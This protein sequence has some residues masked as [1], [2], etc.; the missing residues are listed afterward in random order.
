M[1]KKNPLPPVIFKGSENLELVLLQNT[2]QFFLLSKQE[3]V[4]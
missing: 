2:A 3:I 1:K 4:G